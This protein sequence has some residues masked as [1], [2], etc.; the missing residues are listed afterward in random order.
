MRILVTFALDSEFAPWR[1]LRE[2]RPQKQGCEKAFL[3]NM[4]GAQVMAVL[5]GAGP[6]SAADCAN[7]LFRGARDLP[8]VC[9]SAGFAGALR[10]EYEV[11]DVLVA[12]SVVTGT[13]GNE[14][15]APSSASLVSA[16]ASCGAR[17]ASR[18]CTSEQV[19]TTAATKHQLGEVAD[20]VEMESYYILHGAGP[21]VETVAI[22]AI[23][24]MCDED[25]PLDMNHVFGAPGRVS[26][27]RVMREIV[28]HPLSV[29]ALMRLWK[30]SVI[31]G[32][33]LAD[34]MEKYLK[35]L[36]QLKRE[37]ELSPAA[38]LTTQ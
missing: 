13:A 4:Q 11:G 20:A 8:D 31:A 18:F 6:K 9:I 24:D 37:T 32:K 19:V 7:R 21:K 1:K 3:A 23:S 10:R 27:A 38:V 12:A 35:A 25:L 26:M 34:F 29:P 33:S 28:R 30:Q 16:A 22:R 36:T 2:F 5:T 17:R 14:R 15:E